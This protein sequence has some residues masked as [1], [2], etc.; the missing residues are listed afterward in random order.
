M[1]GVIALDVDRVGHHA[2]GIGE[3]V[4]VDIAAEHGEVG[5]PVALAQA[6]FRPNEAAIKGDTVLQ[7]ECD[8]A[9]GW[10]GGRLMHALLDPDFIVADGVAERGLQDTGIVPTGAITAARRGQRDI[11]HPCGTHGVR[12]GQGDWQRKR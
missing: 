1:Y 2:A 3:V 11:E 9:V 6:D 8:R 12:R 7:G 4:I 5:L 10:I